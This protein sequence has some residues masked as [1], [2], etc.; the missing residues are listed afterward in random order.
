MFR[1]YNGISVTFET[2]S[3]GVGGCRGQLPRFPIRLDVEMPPALLVAT[4]QHG[5]SAT[6]AFHAPR[7]DVFAGR[8]LFTSQPISGKSQMTPRNAI[9]GVDLGI[10][11]WQLDHDVV[12]SVMWGVGLH[13]L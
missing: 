5:G 13:L 4:T 8:V 9:W 1:I 7:N 6:K 10:S 11:F 2:M 12:S 3:I